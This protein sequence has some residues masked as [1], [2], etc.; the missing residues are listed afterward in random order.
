MNDARPVTSRGK[1]RSVTL[2]SCELD[3]LRRVNGAAGF[4]PFEAYARV[5]AR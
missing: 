2:D 3:D 1:P 5:T 4:A